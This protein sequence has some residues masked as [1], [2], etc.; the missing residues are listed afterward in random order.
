MRALIGEDE[1]LMRHGLVLLL[2]RAGITV[3]AA[4]EDGAALLAECER[5]RPDLVL[6]DIRMPPDHRDEGLRATLAIKARWPGTGVVILSHHAQRGVAI[7]ILRNHAT[8]VGYLLKQR[9]ADVDRFVAD[10][11]AVATGRTVLDP[12]VVSLLMSGAPASATEGLTERQ[13]RVLGL[14]ARGHSNAAIARELS[15]SEK[16][17]VHHVSHI[18]DVLGLALTPDTHRRVQAVVMHLGAEWP[19]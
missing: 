12:E 16:S 10:L 3:V 8:G 14:M 1:A 11:R 18:Y 9:V 19:Q 7:D 2:E 4:V 15:L 13:E 17:V 6:T 5:Q